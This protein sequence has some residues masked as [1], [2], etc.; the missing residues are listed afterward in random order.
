MFRFKLLII[1]S[2][3]FGAFCASFPILESSLDNEDTT[4]YEKLCDE[5]I[6]TCLSNNRLV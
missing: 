4:Y 2:L 3:V 6:A 5:V 1:G